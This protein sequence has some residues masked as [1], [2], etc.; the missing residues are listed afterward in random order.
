V[1]L[2]IENSVCY[3]QSSGDHD[4]NINPEEVA[5]KVEDA[6]NII[7]E[8]SSTARQTVR[9]LQEAQYTATE[10]RDTA[11]EVRD[12]HVVA[13]TRSFC[14]DNEHIE[15]LAQLLF[16]FFDTIMRPLPVLINQ[17][18]CAFLHV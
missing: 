4:E 14:H 7:R 11:T 16:P 1:S 2:S 3:H 15:F 10:I 6:A 5:K 17:S 12:S 9:N 8:T 18:F 13:S